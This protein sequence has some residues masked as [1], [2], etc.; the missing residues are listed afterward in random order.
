MTSVSLETFFHQK[1]S[2]NPLQLFFLKIVSVVPLMQHIDEKMF[3]M[4]QMS[5]DSVCGADSEYDVD[6]S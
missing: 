5:F 2:P 3:P 1:C 6:F 4:K